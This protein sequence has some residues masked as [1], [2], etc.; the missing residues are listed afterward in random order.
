MEEN[1]DEDAAGEGG[2][3]GD[4]V[5]ILDSEERSPSA[6]KICYLSPFGL[7]YD[8]TKYAEVLRPKN[9]NTTKSK[10]WDFCITLA[11]GN[12]GTKSVSCLDGDALLPCFWITGC[13]IV[14]RLLASDN[15]AAVRVYLLN[16]IR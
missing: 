3:E 9:S 16:I 2:S 1:G 5:E 13:I 10:V 11:D 8:S 4:I 6:S 14:H 7:P 15:L 12:N